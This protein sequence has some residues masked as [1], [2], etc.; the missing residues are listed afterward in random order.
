MK[1]PEE[2]I[3]SCEWLFLRA[4]DEPH[5]NDLTI[6]VEEA[7]EGKPVDAEEQSQRTGQPSLK[8]VL[9]G[10]RRIDHGPGCRVFRVSWS[11]YVAFGVRNESFTSSDSY[12]VFDGRLLRHYKKSRFLDYIALSTWASDDHPGPLYHTGLVC[13]DHVIDV[14]ATCPP[15]VEFIET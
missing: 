12:E 11:Q 7:K 13:C 3:Q 2:E 8:N 5:E 9:V 6:L 14:V 1:T 4:Y 15:I 10:A